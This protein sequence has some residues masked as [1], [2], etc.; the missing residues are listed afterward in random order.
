MKIRNYVRKHLH[1]TCKPSIV[2]SKR[3]KLLSEV[4]LQE[5]E[6]ILSEG[7]LEASGDNVELITAEEE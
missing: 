6:E 7:L 5:K 2:A 4:E 3:D 1:K